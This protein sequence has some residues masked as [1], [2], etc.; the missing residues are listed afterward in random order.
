MGIFSGPRTEKRYNGFVAQFANPPIYS[1]GQLGTFGMS[2][3]AEGSMQ[4]V[5]I[6]AAVNLIASLARELPFDVFTGHGGDKKPQTTPGYLLDI[7]GD[8][9]GTPDWIYQAL[10]SFLLRGN[11][12]GKVVARDSRG[13]FPTQVPLIHPDDVTGWRD[14]QTGRKVWRVRGLDTPADDMWHRRVYTVP[15]VL[16]GL[17]PIAYHAASIGL[18]LTSQKF[19]IDFFRDG[20]SPTGILANAE[21]DLTKV[22]VDTAK[23]RFMA[24][25][26]GGREPVVLGK[27]WE[28]KQ[29][30]IAPEESQF[31]ETQKYSASECA[32]I[33]G[34]GM[35]E[36]LGYPTGDSLTYATVEGRSLHLLTYTLDP[37]FALIERM[38]SD[39]LPK[40]RYVKLNRAALLRTDLLTRYRAHAMAI[41][42][43]WKAPSEVRDDE[44]MPPMTESQ[45][46]ELAAIGL[47]ALPELNETKEKTT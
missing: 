37:W 6:W 24:A 13:G 23:S 33:Y 27:G 3:R 41:A 40:P 38:M 18:V 21:A 46:A 47:P 35:P 28:W 4:A 11:V 26:N 39:L 1:N 42:A 32:R 8:G 19:G 22:Q 17:S 29:I 14:P 7:A 2:A 12:Y 25:M 20:A 16:Q 9:Y 43:H 30:S 10:V 36:I 31:I 15:G 34:P 44:D 45:Q 5:A